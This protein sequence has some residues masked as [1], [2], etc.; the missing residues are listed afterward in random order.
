MG[1]RGSSSRMKVYGSANEVYQDIK[2]KLGEI[3]GGSEKQNAYAK[4]VRNK[5]ISEY[6]YR[7]FDAQNKNRLI[8]EQAKSYLKMFKDNYDFALKETNA[9]KILDRF[10]N[11]GV[12]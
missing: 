5:I 1:G 11:T 3:S 2:K 9:K 8:S 10:V 6:S 7:V 12:F 4:S